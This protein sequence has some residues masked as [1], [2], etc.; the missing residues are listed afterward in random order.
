MVSTARTARMAR[1]AT[2][3]VILAAFAVLLGCLQDSAQPDPLVF[4]GPSAPVPLWGP[5][6]SFSVT[7]QN[8]ITGQ[9][10]SFD[11]SGSAIGPGHTIASYTWSFGGGLPATAT[12]VMASSTYA[13]DG[14]Y[15]VSLTVTDNLTPSTSVTQRAPVVVG[16]P[17][18]PTAVIQFTLVGTTANFDGTA[19][20]PGS[21]TITTYTWNFG[22]GSGTG[23]GATTSHTYT[24]GPTPPTT[25][26]V[27][28]TV[29]N[30]L[31]LTGTATADVIL[32]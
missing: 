20:T 24:A 22:D 7:P 12:G 17:T 13:S 2:I 29:T 15:T 25:F 27:T 14:T 11:A 19:S 10:V 6:P 21:G 31:A 30:S 1:A 32:P 23:T 9:A 5:V 28:L 16:A 4:T 18:P 26:T 3:T 8:P